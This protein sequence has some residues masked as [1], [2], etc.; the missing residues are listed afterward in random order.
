MAPPRAKSRSW[1]LT[2]L[3]VG[4]PLWWAL[5][6]SGLI[7]MIAALPMAII[8][9]GRTPIRAPRGFG[10]YMLFLTWVFVSMSQAEGLRFISVGYRL[11]LYI[12]TAVVFL[13]VYNLSHEELPRTR[14]LKLAVVYMIYSVAGGYLALILHDLEFTSVVERLLP[15]AVRSNEYASSLV[16]PRFAQNHEFLGFPL[17]RP[18]VPFT[19]TN[20]WGSGVALLTPLF[21]AAFAGL[22]RRWRS[23]IVVTGFAALIPIVISVNRGLWLTLLIA[24]GYGA[25][26]LASRGDIKYFK[27]LVG[28]GAAIA[29]VLLLTP[30]GGLVS[31]RIANGHSDEGRMTL[32]GQVI[33]QIQDSPWVGY[34]APRVNEE[35]PNLPAVGTHGQF[36]TVLYSH[37]IPGA[38][39]YV[40]FSLGLAWRT[41]KGQDRVGVWIHV[42]TALVPILMWFYELINQPIFLVFVAGAIALR[43]VP[44]ASTPSTSEAV[45]PASIPQPHQPT[46]THKPART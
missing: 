25:V 7:W 18:T 17:Y 34:G 5:G 33:D 4:M 38:L 2:L 14:V 6:L 43:G 42:T 30:L 19:F 20:E 23:A 21:I 35:R 31:G 37:G 46:G 22:D 39:L 11:V 45:A 28:L 27:G 8:T 36:W 10:L 24:V 15:A 32:Y 1:P 16:H 44:P 40:S 12:A 26:M 29:V 41:L 9:L 3:I 13:Y